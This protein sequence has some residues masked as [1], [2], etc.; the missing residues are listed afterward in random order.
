MI[1]ELIDRKSWVIDIE[2]IYCCFTYTGLNID[3]KEVVQFV[4]H[5]NRFELDNLVNHLKEC[6]GHITFNGL[7]FDYPVIH[8]ILI[9]YKKWLILLERHITY[10]DVILEIYN[11][12][13]RL[14][15]NQNKFGNSIKDSDCFIKQLDLF[16]LNHFDNKAKIMSLKAVEIAINYHNVMDMPIKHDIKELNDDQVNSTLVYNYND[17]DATYEFYKL[18]INKINLRKDLSAKY[19]INLINA[20]DS[21]IGTEI[22]KQEYSKLS[23]KSYYEYKDLRTHFDETKLLRDIIS[24]KVSY[25]STYL[26]EF[27]VELKN[28]K[29][30]D[31]KGKDLLF[32]GLKSNVFTGGLH[33]DMPSHIYE[34]KEDE[35][36]IDLDFGSYYPGLMLSLG[37]YPKHLGVEFLDVLRELTNRR[38]NAKKNKDM[39]TTNSLKITINSIFGNL[40]S[41]YSFIY[42][43]EA[44]YT[45]TM[46]G[47]LF[48]LMLCEQLTNYDGVK[49]FY[50]NTD[51]AS[52]IVKKSLESK[53]Y[54]I[55]EEFSKFINI[56]VE[57]VKYKKCII[58]DC[59]NYIILTEE[60]KIKYKGAFV[61]DREIY[62]DNSFR[63][64]PIAI[65]EY[66]INNISVE[67]TIN[68]HTNI[69]DFCGRQKFGRDSYGEI[70]YLEDN[71]YK[72]DK[73]QKN[74]RYYISKSGKRFIKQY[75]KGST[76][77]INKGYEV[78]I[79]NKFIEK[80]FKDYK[81]DKSFYIKECY[82]IIQILEPQQIS[83][84]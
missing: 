9:N 24:D 77:I 10:E 52:F 36:I 70:H 47:Q 73:Q 11:E 62:Q 56:G 33:S 48:L 76:E 26:K 42:S 66:F 3:T 45:V 5:K 69:Y 12:A 49:C 72:V 21:K 4:L 17:V 53:F 20:S 58:R 15:N 75:T 78:E 46:N 43:P 50:Q 65:S 54:E 57:F 80:D 19:G 28:T 30:K 44:L 84:F 34:P 18:C 6:K 82:K 14:I 16:K 27:L 23:G 35:I 32:R 51:G 40:G 60:G 29:F 31:F 41:E 68:N 81:I 25:E 59:N 74:V 2:T 7:N 8:F 71:Q 63:I 67:Q 39:V 83:M 22:L 13:Q 79:F 38:L 61:I 1:Q 64:I 55:A 37:I